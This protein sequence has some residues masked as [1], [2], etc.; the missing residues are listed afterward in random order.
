MGVNSGSAPQQ[1]TRANCWNAAGRPPPLP[2]PQGKSSWTDT[3]DTRPPK[4]PTQV[5]MCNWQDLNSAPC[6]AKARGTFLTQTR[7]S[8]TPL[9]TSSNSTLNGQESRNLL[10]T[11]SFA[12]CDSPVD[13]ASFPVLRGMETRRNPC[14]RNQ[15]HTA[16]IR[17][18]WPVCKSPGHTPWTM[19]PRPDPK[20]DQGAQDLASYI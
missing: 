13:C 9:D 15:G 20:Q 11:Y 12:S 10:C 17:L 4:K 8:R 19:T 18:R 14:S 16:R 2:L 1:K 6:V 7:H 3:S 5:R